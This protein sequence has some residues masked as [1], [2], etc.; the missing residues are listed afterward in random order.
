MTDSRS[1]SGRAHERTAALPIAASAG[2]PAPRQA[3]AFTLSLA[4]A[5][6]RYGASADR[7]E[8]AVG[9]VAERLGLKA[10]FF[11]APTSILASYVTTKG[12]ITRM[13]RLGGAE[14]DLAKLADV[15]ALISEVSAGRLSPG[16]GRD[17]LETTHA[18][19]RV[20]STGLRILA[21]GLAGALAA[22]LFGGGA[23]EA[24]AA[25]PIALVVGLLGLWAGRSARSRLL[26]EPLAALFGAAAAVQA[27][28]LV[29][30][31]SSYNVTLSALIL[32]VPGLSLTTAMR[33]LAVQHLTAG[34]TR[35]TSALMSLVG[36]GLG[37]GFGRRIGEAI[38]WSGPAFEKVGAPA[39]TEPAAV[40]TM[41]LAL[42]VFAGARWRDLGA[43]AVGCATA[44]YGARL[45]AAWAGPEVGAFAGACAVGIAS[46][47]YARLHDRP[48]SMMQLPGTILLVPGSIG[49]KSVF[50]LLN[51]ET[52][53]G[54]EAA[55][56]MIVIGAALVF[57]LLF[58]NFVVPPR[59]AL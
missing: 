45:G 22:R 19:P 27:E 34:T 49:F 7:I 21:S 33:E 2:G 48:S 39:W 31:L 6:H 38:A 35:L 55:V 32:L 46:N 13:I 10:Q 24:L 23:S 50:A 37:V 3:I 57:G 52:V 25:F 20:W 56:N 18:Q 53:P 51:R 59:R 58:A 17:R 28:R 44:F 4:E 16:D 9:T 15:D 41:P 11:A 14:I 43:V 54:L 5:L 36:L 47:L 12:S 42:M 30:G 40:L 26:Y 8:D 29:P 1:E